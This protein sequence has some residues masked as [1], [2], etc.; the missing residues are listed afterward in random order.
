MG[1]RDKGHIQR[2]SLLLQLLARVGVAVPVPNEPVN[3]EQEVRQFG[4]G[5]DST[6]SLMPA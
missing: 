6:H 2:I 4:Q 1:T 3:S 5:S